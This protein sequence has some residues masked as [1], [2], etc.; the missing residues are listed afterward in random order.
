MRIYE[1]TLA[2]RSPSYQEAFWRDTLEV[3]VREADG[4]IEVLLQ[5]STIRFEP[6]S[7]ELDPATTSPSTSR[8]GRSRRRLP[9]SRNAMRCLPF[10]ATPTL[11]RP[12][13]TG[14][15]PAAAQQLGS[16]FDRHDRG[17]ISTALTL[18]LG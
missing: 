2:T 13:A 17:P 9:G 7:P 14:L 5:A 4:G 3:P 16:K 10:T 18:V 15:R 6:A 8:V 1:L 12:P 11:S